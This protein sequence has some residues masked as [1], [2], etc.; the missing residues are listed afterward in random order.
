MEQCNSV[1]RPARR[2]DIGTM[3]G[4]SP[5]RVLHVGK[6]YPP[7]RG[8]IESYLKDLVAALQRKGIVCKAVVHDPAG[9][10][11]RGGGEDNSLL[12]RAVSYGEILYTPIS[13]GF[14]MALRSCVEHFSPN[15]IHLHLPNVSAF[16][17]MAIP[18]ARAV[19]WVIQWQSDVVP[20]AIDP[21][22]RLAYSLYRPFEQSL[23][24]RA[25]AVI[26]SSRAYLEGSASL[27]PWRDKCCIVPLGLDP[28]R[29]PLPDAGALER[30]ERSWECGES[31]RVLAVG[32]LTYYKGF[33]VLLEAAGKLKDVRVQ[34]VGDGGLRRELTEKI[35]V[36]GLHGRVKLLGEVSDEELQGLLV[37][38]DCLCLPSIER[39]EAFGMVMLEAMHYGLRI[40]ASDIPGSGVGWVARKSGSCILFRPGDPYELAYSL[41]SLSGT[42]G[43]RK[44]NSGESRLPPQLHIDSIASTVVSIYREILEPGRGNRWKSPY[45]ANQ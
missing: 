24:R 38:A 33:G 26:V 7:I 23:L 41:K 4:G 35:R 21:R 45:K 10:K 13:P 37:T 18:R 40:V 19:P 36:L 16:W 11:G 6:Y 2:D 17:C 12:V 31:L 3:T 20:S 43:L 27:I 39:T 28:G 44:I 34:I 8:G 14:P 9:R 15:I 5:F 30:A 22:L 25:A 29:L 32:R 1:N 42:K